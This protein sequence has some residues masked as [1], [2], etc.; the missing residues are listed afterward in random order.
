VVYISTISGNCYRET[1]VNRISVD[2]LFKKSSK[3]IIKK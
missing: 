3:K 1:E 2:R